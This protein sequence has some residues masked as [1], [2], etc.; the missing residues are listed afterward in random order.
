VSTERF[1]ESAVRF[2]NQH[3]KDA[4]TKTELYEH[5]HSQLKSA[6]PQ[7]SPT[8]FIAEHIPTAL[9]KPFREHLKQEGVS[10]T[11]FKKDL[12]DIEHRLKRY[13][14]ITKKGAVVT[15]PSENADLID[16]KIDRIVVNDPVVTV[17]KK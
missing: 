17:N 1:Y 3:V 10:M 14:Y 9:Q 6:K 13:S 15:V 16:V 5:L 7:L 4:V 12:A 8:T 2:T 11:A